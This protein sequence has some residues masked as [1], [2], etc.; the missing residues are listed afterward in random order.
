M[1]PKNMNYIKNG[2]M[3]ILKQIFPPLFSGL[4]SDAKV[5]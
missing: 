5:S 3:N 2:H 4:N 1:G